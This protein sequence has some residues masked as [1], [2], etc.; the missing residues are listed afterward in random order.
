MN[1]KLKKLLPLLLACATTITLLS[2]CA[3][4]KNAG[5]DT[6]T[7]SNSSKAEIVAT[8]TKLP[9][10]DKPIT[11]TMHQGMD[12]SVT[13]VA[14]SYNDVPAI[15][16][17]EKRTGVH[18]E[19]IHFTT[20]YDENVRLLISSRNFPDIFEYAWQ[21]YPGGPAKAISDEVL[22]PLNELVDKYSPNLKKYFEK[23]PIAGKLSKTDDGKIYMFPMSNGP[24]RNWTSA[25]LQ[26]RQ[27]WLDKLN[28]KMPT[29]TDEWYTVLKAIKEKDPNGNGKADEIPF[30]ADKNNVFNY[31]CGGMG[32]SATGFNQINGKVTFGPTTPEFKEY[33]KVVSKWY[34][35]GLIDPDYMVND[36]KTIQAKITGDKAGSWSNYISN[37]K[38][39]TD[40]MKPQI[41][42]VKISGSPVP[43]LK[44]GETPHGRHN[45][46]VI[47][48]LRGAGITTTSKN[49]E[50]AAKW[51]DYLFSPEGQE[52]VL[53]GIEGESYTKENGKIKLTEKVTNNPEK[54]PLASAMAKHGG[55]VFG[56]FIYARDEYYMDYNA[57][58]PEQQAALNTWLKAKNERYLPPITPAEED[59]AKFNTIMTDVKTY[60]E[61]MTNKFIMGIE[62][63]E[64]FDKYLQRVKELRIEEATKINQKAYDSFMKR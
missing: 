25:G 14:K 36:S 6:N 7:N 19:F 16:E 9:I 3:K 55:L 13:S 30:I 52:L 20:S 60:V 64:N 32:I 39:Y 28:L 58:L 41:P 24:E 63:I 38:T 46:G 40:L 2:G 50:V 37:I 17:L 5:S 59:A 33:L 45:Q 1:S 29:N 43:T 11:L 49:K 21:L 61:E 12:G 18:I 47:A 53:W 22:T 42:G 62:P 56:R 26:I 51:L 8:G 10:V 27:D 54:L 57:P 4:N 48:S 44:A 23:D 31:L 35:E 34:K 15:K